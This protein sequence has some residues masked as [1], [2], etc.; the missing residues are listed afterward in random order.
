MGPPANP[1]GFF[2]APIVVD[3]NKEMEL[4]VIGFIWCDICEMVSTNKWLKDLI[5]AP[6]CCF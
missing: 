2:F 4:P 1:G 6:F 3:G 5:S